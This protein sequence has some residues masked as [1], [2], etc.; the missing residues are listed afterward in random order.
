[1][2]H[3]DIFNGS[4]PLQV[5][6]SLVS[7]RLAAGEDPFPVTF[8][9]RVSARTFEAARSAS[10][11]GM[12]GAL[13]DLL[14]QIVDSDRMSAREKRKRLR[15][16]RETHPDVYRDIFPSEELE[17]DF[18]ASKDNKDSSSSLRLVGG[19]LSKIRSVMRI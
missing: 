2:R 16:F 11:E 1:M 10:S 9:R 3:F 8:C 4:L 19:S 14:A 6:Q 7:K 12:R 15:K 13:H 5:Y 18:M 17:P